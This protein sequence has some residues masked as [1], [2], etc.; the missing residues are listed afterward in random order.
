MGKL[1]VSD[2]VT[3]LDKYKD[4]LIL[5]GDKAIVT[6]GEVDSN[7]LTNKNLRRNPTEFWKHY[8]EVVFND[9]EAD[10]SPAQ[11]AVAALKNKGFVKDIIN[12]TTDSK[13]NSLGDV[14]NLHGVSD[15]FKCTSCKTIFTYDYVQTC[16][17]SEIKCEVCGRPLRPTILLNG[18]NYYDDQYN[19]FK[20]LLLE[21]HTLFVV[22]LDWSESPIV[23]L[24]ADYSDMKQDRN[25]R[26]EEQRMIVV[27][28]G[29]DFIDVNEVGLF[30]FFVSGDV[31][32]SMQRLM[33]NI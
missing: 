11:K 10:L 9:P 27:V 19:A 23:N 30:E 13:L 28:G 33:S 16:P 20:H 6:K 8:F 17:E 15:K 14:I 5:I 29:D 22:G 31:N 32:E 12:L 24:I 21:T 7:I 1:T 3:H 18:E 25:A 2:L 26:E 4:A